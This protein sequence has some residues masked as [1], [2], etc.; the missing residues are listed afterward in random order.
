MKSFVDKVSL[1]KLN[2]D[3]ALECE[4]FINKNEILKALSSMDN[5]KTPGNDVITEEFYVN[6][7]SFLKTILFFDTTVSFGKL[8]QKQVIII[9]NYPNIEI[10]QFFSHSFL[11]SAY[12]DGDTLFLRNKK[13]TLELINTFE[14]RFLFF[15]VLKSVK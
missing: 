4:G 2:D 10:L 7:G 13:K 5:D 8:S 6:F 3:Q 9:L 14:I 1:P 15:L 11:Y 12:A